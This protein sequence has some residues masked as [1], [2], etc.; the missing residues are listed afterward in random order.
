[1]A[2]RKES[3]YAL[4]LVFLMAAVIAIS[5]YSEIPRVA[6]Q[7][8]RH[9]EQ[10]LMGRGLQYMR[11]IQV[12]QQVNKGQWPRNID[13][14]ENFQMRHFL[15]HKYLDPV[16]GKAEW[17]LIHVQGNVL[18]D[19]L[20]TQNPAANKQAASTE[21]N[22]ISTYA[23]LGEIPL[24]DQV[25]RPQDRRRSSEGS[26]GGSTGGLSP[27]MP[28]AGPDQPG[29]PSDLPMPGTTP[30]NPSNP[31]AGAPTQG[32]PGAQPGVPGMPGAPG[33]PGSIAPGQAMPDAGGSA[34]IGA[35]MP[36]QPGMGQQGPGMPGLPGQGGN[37]AL[38]MINRILMNPNPQAA[39]TV[40]QAQQ[41]GLSGASG[42]TTLGGGL[43]GVASKSELEGI[44]VYNS[45]TLYKKWEFVFDPTK[46][47]PIAGGGSTT[48]GA[49]PVSQMGSQP[50]GTGMSSGL[51]QPGGMGLSGG[52]G[53]PGG[54]GMSGGMGQPGGM[55][56]SGGMG[57]SGGIGG[58]GS[59]AQTGTG[60]QGNN[61]SGA[62]PN[63]P[64]GMQTGG[65]GSGLLPPGFRLGRP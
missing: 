16:T 29:Q 1:M 24:G 12:F 43:A 6:F 39:Q 58:M 35:Q 4:L 17:R 26:S 28:G 15:R 13:D 51:G 2:K 23:G 57:M 65:T 50:S 52:L 41:M 47:P 21:S 22:Y 11:A 55:G 9:K 32:A 7:S 37:P 48:K 8:Q 19:S 60:A 34:G 20:L 5:L 3:G 14:V 62:N 54:M 61:A 46:V 38:S 45:Q 18:T 44:M 31:V 59:G 49:T 25:Q 42:S 36:G 63:S 40:Q 33:M 53:Q 56:I 30:D 27:M 64:A 10:L